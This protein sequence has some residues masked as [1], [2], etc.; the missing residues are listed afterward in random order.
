MVSMGSTVVSRS[1]LLYR[2]P[3]H[4]CAVYKSVYATA[5]SADKRSYRSAASA[6]LL[7]TAT[8]RVSVPAGPNTSKSVA[9]SKLMVK[10]QMRAS[11]KETSSH[12]TYILLVNI[13]KISCSIVVALLFW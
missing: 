4:F 9:P 3:F 5:V 6:N 11:G 1:R 8:E 10:L 13:S 12:H 7:I 2:F